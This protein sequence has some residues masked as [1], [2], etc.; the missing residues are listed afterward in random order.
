MMSNIADGLTNG[1]DM[2]N[3]NAKA[4]ERPKIALTLRIKNWIWN[5]IIDTK[6]GW[7]GHIEGVI[8][9]IDVDELMSNRAEEYNQ[10]INDC[11]DY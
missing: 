2:P 7:H 1:I 4:F 5:N 9:D 8:D 10:G 6:L 3:A 11:Y